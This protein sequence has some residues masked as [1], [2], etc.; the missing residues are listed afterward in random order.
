MRV[1]AKYL[2]SEYTSSNGQVKV[3]EYIG[4]DANGQ[5]W[6]Y[7]R[8]VA[9]TQ[10]GGGLSAPYDFEEIGDEVQR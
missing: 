1:T 8:K 2:L 5:Q 10:H 6:K 9:L 4:V 7:K 3:Y